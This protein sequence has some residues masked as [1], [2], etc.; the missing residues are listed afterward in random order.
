MSKRSI[1]SNLLIV[2][3]G[4][5]SLP[6]SQAQISTQSSSLKISKYRDDPYVA[7]PEIDRLDASRFSQDDNGNTVLSG[8]KVYL[9]EETF[10]YRK[11]AAGVYKKFAWN[12]WPQYTSSNEN[13]HFKFSE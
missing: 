8:D 9:G 11:D 13:G 7:E 1:V 3:I 4:L 10:I 12:P 5:L 2:V 6:I